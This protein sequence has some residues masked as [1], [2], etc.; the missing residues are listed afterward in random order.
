MSRIVALIV[1]GA[2]SVTALPAL[3]AST[4]TARSSAVLAIHTRPSASAPTVGQLAKNEVVHLAECTYYS[5]WCYVLRNKG[6]EGW[7]LGSY[8]VG[9]PAKLQVTPQ[10]LFDNPFPFLSRRDHRHH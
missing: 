8:L 9:S 4:A 5:R 2:L 10:R 1:A 7:V 3:A 6:P